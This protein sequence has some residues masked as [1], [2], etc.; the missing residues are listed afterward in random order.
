MGEIAT[1]II[2]S[3]SLP[4]LHFLSP[5]SA[6]AQALKAFRADILSAIE[7]TNPE[8]LE[9][10]LIETWT[11]LMLEQ[12][13]EYSHMKQTKDPEIAEYHR[14]NYYRALKARQSTEKFFVGVILKKKPKKVKSLKDVFDKARTITI[15]INKK[16]RT[17]VANELLSNRPVFIK[18]KSYAKRKA[19]MIGRLGGTCT[20]TD[21]NCKSHRGRRCAATKRLEPDHIYGATWQHEKYGQIERMEKYEQDEKDGLLRLLCRSCNAT[22]GA[23]NKQGKSRYTKVRISKRKSPPGVFQTAEGGLSDHVGDPLS[24]SR[25]KSTPNSFRPNDFLARMR[26]AKKK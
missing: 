25:N 6:E 26:A 9:H 19:E 20:C 23:K 2:Q 16:E 18:Q 7:T 21:L 17:F 3:N 12:A 13:T 10:N 1:H 22:D 8:L 11:Q 5:E 14:N 15:P 24:E 4:V